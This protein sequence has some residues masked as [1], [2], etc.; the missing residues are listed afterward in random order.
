MLDRS[1]TGITRNI[2][3]ILILRTTIITYDSEVSIRLHKHS[4]INHIRSV[5]YCHDFK[6]HDG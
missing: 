5:F 4:L 3:A 6:L 1:G 2:P